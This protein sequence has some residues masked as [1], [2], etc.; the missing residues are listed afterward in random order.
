MRVRLALVKRDSPQD[1]IEQLLGIERRTLAERP[2]EPP[3]LSFVRHETHGLLGTLHRSAI[4]GDVFSAQ[5]HLV[6]PVKHGPFLLRLRGD[7]FL[8]QRE[9]DRCVIVLIGGEQWF[10]R[11]HAPTSQVSANCLQRHFN[12]E[13]ALDLT[14]LGRQRPEV[15]RQLKLIRQRMEDE[16]LN[17]RRLHLIESCIPRRRSIMPIGVE[18]P[19]RCR[20]VDRDRFVGWRK[21]ESK[22]LPYLRLRQTATKRAYHRKMCKCASTAPS[23]SRAITH[24]VN[25][26]RLRTVLCTDWQ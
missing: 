25:E 23:S 17:P 19:Q 22:H 14:R 9:S 10:L 18:C 8:V 7:H 15:R 24:V 12:S 6:S 4:S 2:N 11:P 16:S 3:P 5:A 26:I 20:V 13:L 1:S 21:A